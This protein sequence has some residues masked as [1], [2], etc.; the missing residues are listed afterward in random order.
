VVIGS[1]AAAWAP[2]PDLAAVVVLDEH[3]ERL[4]EERAPTWHARDVAVER[5]ARA[6]APCVLASPVPSL[7]ALAWGHL[8][9][10]SRAEERAG[11]P[12]VEIVD[13]SREEP[14]KT[15][16]LSSALLRHIREGRHVVCVLN[17]TGRARLLACAAC[18]T[19]ARCEVCEAAVTQ[20]DDHVLRCPRCGA[21]RPVVCGHCGG[22]RFRALRPGV[23]RLRD[24]LAASTGVDV[25][26]VTASSPAPPPDAPVHVG[27]EAVLHQVVSADVVAYLDIDGELL[28]PRYRAAEEAAALLVLGARLV[29][30]RSGGGR[31][32]VQTRLPHHEVLQAALLAD[33]GRLVDAERARREALGFPP[34]RALAAVSGPAAG[35]LIDGLRAVLDE[36]RGAEVEVLG[37]AAGVWLVRAPDH[38]TLA[39]VLAAT[40]RPSGRVRVAVDPLRV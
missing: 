3:D 29:G 19:L 1:R 35:E 23:A 20:P 32:L 30:G 37:P 40:P 36:A 2:M 34:A 15:S 31:L 14:W 26:E 16:L 18:T 8:L 28:P 12:I 13:R 10:V 33:P 25:V 24:E 4:Q 5:A 7:E 22:T 38:A 9:T 21:E 27:T 11:W 6:G 39:D 17:T